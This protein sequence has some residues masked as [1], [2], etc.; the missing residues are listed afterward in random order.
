MNGYL[1]YIDTIRA[2]VAPD[3]ITI[4]MKSRNEQIELADQYI[5]TQLKSPELTEIS[6]D[7]LLPAHEYPF[8]VYAA[9]KYTTSTEFQT[10]SWFINKW[11]ALMKNKQACRLYILRGTKAVSSDATYLPVTIES[12]TT[13]EDADGRGDIVLSMSLKKYVDNATK[14][15][16]FDSNN[17]Y[18]IT[19][20]RSLITAETV[21]TVTVPYNNSKGWEYLLTLGKKY[22]LPYAYSG[23][24]DFTAALRI[25]NANRDTIVEAAKNHYYYYMKQTYKTSSEGKIKEK[26]KYTEEQWLQERKKLHARADYLCWRKLRKDN[27][28]NIWSQR[29]Y[30]SY[31]YLV[32]GTVLKM[33][34][35]VLNKDLKG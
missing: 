4:K 3:S 30:K 18:T 10:A 31:T 2:P 33:P 11:Q 23:L 24:N 5:F 12:M 28:S 9:N 27:D 15:L 20:T 17:N 32:K 6:F 8:A 14:I 19:V 21:D 13:K 1:I 29:L 7:L 26:N 25:F 16:T 34:L 22:R 35:D